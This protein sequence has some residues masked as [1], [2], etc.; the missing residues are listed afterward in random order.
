MLVID[1]Y[2]TSVYFVIKVFS[3]RNVD[4]YKLE[5]TPLQV[6]LYRRLTFTKRPKGYTTKTEFDN[7]K[8]SFL[9]FL[10]ELGSH[11]FFGTTEIKGTT[12]QDRK[13]I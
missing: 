13:S 10:V 1:K 7:Y 11:T 12:F 6:D 4:N 3:E 2:S 8:L 9:F 5:T